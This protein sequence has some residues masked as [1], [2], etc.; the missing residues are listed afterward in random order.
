MKHILLS[1]ALCALSTLSILA[2]DG[3]LLWLPRCPESATATVTGGG[4]SATAR[5]ARGEL[6]SYCTSAARV[7]L[8]L[9]GEEPLGEG[10]RLEVSEADSSVCI[11]SGTDT[12]LLYGAFA[13]LRQQS[14]GRI[15]SCSEEP[16]YRLRMLNHWD[17][18]DGS[19]ERGY[20]GRSIFW[21][22][23]L[24]REEWRRR[25]DAY[26][27]ANASLGINAVVLNNVNAS[28]DVLTAAYL[29]SVRMIADILRPWGVRVCLAVNFASPKALGATATADP[30]DAEVARWWRD[31]AKDIYAL[32]PDFCG[33]LVKANSEGQP[34]PFDYGRTHADGAN[35]LADALAPYGGTVVWRSFVYGAKHGGE[36]RVKQAVSEFK[37]LD[38]AF[39]PNVILQSKNGPLDFQPRE[40][41]APIFDNMSRTRQ[42]AELQ[43]TQ[44]YLGQ[45]RHLVYL[46]TM[47]REFFS[48]VSPDRLCGVAGV[49]NVGDD[50]NWCGHDFS[51]SNWYAFGRL[52]WDPALDAA[53]IA[54]EWLS[55]TFTP[56]SGFT[57]PVKRLMMQSREDCVDYMMPLGLHH[58]F[59]FDHHYGPEPDG[60]KADYPPEWCPVYYH[61][62]DSIGIG[63]DRTMSGSGAVGQYR[64]PY[65]TLYGSLDSC[66][67]EYLLWFHHV[68]WTHVMAD[69]RT[70][71]DNLC[72]HYGRGVAHVAGYRRVWKEVKPLVLSADRS[73]PGR[74]KERWKRVDDLLKVQ[75]GDAEEW[76][77]TCLNYFSTFSKMPY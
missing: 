10:F 51:Q 24:P 68:P 77:G 30:L 74:D 44:E 19:V 32:I 31:K 16:Y 38:G 70:L 39:R 42:M 8:V 64:E 72:A 27:R 37:E 63:F 17:N 5:L 12:G 4:E 3:S 62:A 59:K 56:D 45:S 67:E 46:A 36:D 26:G 40:P 14:V 25:I 69:G 47:W 60:Y 76:C 9:T 55:Q 21:N 73:L 33:F 54:G 75:L 23:R 41:Y 29:D 50:P 2:Y 28:P 35:M 58:I 65:R 43:V 20:A 49:A 66:P 53:D 13:L 15:H 57:E 61:K 22:S 6:E 7:R 1:C 11:I 34:G 48:F 18:L 52:A 71:W